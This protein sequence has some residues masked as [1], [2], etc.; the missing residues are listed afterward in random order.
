MNICKQRPD[1][2][3][4][5][6]AIGL[7]P[8]ARYPSAVRQSGRLGTINTSGIGGHQPLGLARQRVGSLS[9][10]QSEFSMGN[11]Q[12][13]PS[14]FKS[15]YRAQYDASMSGHG[16]GGVP[17]KT[18]MAER[19][20]VQRDTENSELSKVKR[21]RS[22]R[23]NNR[24]G[25]ARASGLPAASNQTPISPE[26]V[27]PLVVSE[28]RWTTNV[29]KHNEGHYVEQSQILEHVTGQDSAIYSEVYAQLSQKIIERVSQKAGANTTPSTKT[30]PVESSIF[31]D[32]LV[33]Y[34]QNSF[35]QDWM[36][37]EDLTTIAARNEPAHALPRFDNYYATAKSKRQRLGLV[38][39]I[40]ALFKVQ[41][42]SERTVRECIEKLLSNNDNLAEE[43]AENLC[44]LLVTVGPILDTPEAKEDIDIIFD[45][46]SNISTEEN[47]KSR[48][49][50]MLQNVIELRQ[51]H[52]QKVA[53]SRNMSVS[54]SEAD[55]VIQLGD[56]DPA[57]LASKDEV[58][59]FV[60]QAVKYTASS[61][62]KAT[63][64]FWGA[65]ERKSS[66]DVGSTGS[67]ATKTSYSHEKPKEMPGRTNTRND[68][69]IIPGATS[70]L[71]GPRYSQ[72]SHRGLGPHSR[73]PMSSPGSDDTPT[74]PRYGSVSSAPGS[75]SSSQHHHPMGSFQAPSPPLRRG[76][77]GH[78]RNIQTEQRDGA[79]SLKVWSSGLGGEQNAGRHQ[80]WQ[81]NF[82]SISDQIIEW[83][84]K[85]EQEKDGFTLMLVIRHIFEKARDET[86]PSEIH[87][88]LCRKIMEHISPNVQEEDVRDR[89]TYFERGWSAK[90]AV[91]AL[92]V[93]NP[94]EGKAAEAASQANGKAALHSEE[95]YAAAKAKRQGVGL[96]RFLGELFKVRML[97]ERIMHE[98]IKKLLSNAVNPEE[99]EIESVCALLTTVGRMLDTA[100]AKTHM[101]IY[102]ERMA[103]ISRAGNI[104]WKMKL[105]LNSTIELRQ[106]GWQI[107]PNVGTQSLA[108][109]KFIE[110]ASKISYPDGIF[111]PRLNQ[112]GFPD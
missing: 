106:Q 91:A 39:F 28:D 85:S 45:R 65:G 71:T 41:I 16:L 50:F 25:P 110:D 60:E 63:N 90:E 23:G 15:S 93:G 61:Q 104:S 26:P 35:E 108:A 81:N 55:K 4:P 56:R 112:N 29:M 37:Q 75:T 83:A 22:Q 53:R 74:F 36:V 99:E 102:F 100:K 40:G 47:T 96:A 88:L 3:P 20:L 21:A 59:H 68:E 97:T 46:M 30:Q 98:C 51:H 2:L 48:V 44:D 94:G 9:L 82:D 107:T 5:L 73:T 87:A 77:P 79:D 101:D 38:R 69:D 17:F 54:F 72:H 43:R 76:F 33:T 13:P 66:V 32:S 10:S 57:S 103:G 95:Y 27:K 34:C 80:T 12:A 92:A 86:E 18:G 84:N 109:A 1:S 6:D 8:V 105:I 24:N 78:Y 64:A 19:P 31:R 52:W 70:P 111:G 49:R 62:P 7:E 67:L 42:L 11:F 58:E 14:P 89:R